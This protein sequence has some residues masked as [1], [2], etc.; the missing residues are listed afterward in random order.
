MHHHNKRNIRKKERL[1]RNNLLHGA[2]FF[3]KGY[4][5]VKEIYAIIF[6]T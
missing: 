4:F 2:L 1:I 6:E 5:R 3:L